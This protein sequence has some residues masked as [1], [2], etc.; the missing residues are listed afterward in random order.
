MERFIANRLADR[1]FND[2]PVDMG[3]RPVAWYEQPSRLSV[4]R[5]NASMNAETKDTA[6][7]KKAKKK[8][9]KKDG[10]ATSDGT[11]PGRCWSNYTEDSDK[12]AYSK[13]SCKPEKKDSK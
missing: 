1:R 5:S 2:R 4:K 11:D 8:K 3:S 6:S 13:G 9:E 7:P 12:E 10:G